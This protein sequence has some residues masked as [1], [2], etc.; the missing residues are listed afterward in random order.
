[1]VAGLLAMASVGLAGVAQGGGA[2]SQTSVV[3]QPGDTLWSISVA[4]Y[5]N[6]DPRE[7]IAAIERLNGL[8]GPL[9]E[10]GESLQLP[11]P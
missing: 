10:A 9:I 11:P 4:H 5:P 1:M 7:R 8:Q 3:V 6:A 2:P